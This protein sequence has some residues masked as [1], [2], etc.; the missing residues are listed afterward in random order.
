MRELLFDLRDSLRGFRRNRLY[1]ITVVATLAL[2]LGA[3]T[4]VFSI[5]NGV[6]LRPLA[7]PESQNLVSIREVIPRIAAQYPN[8]PANARHFEE[9]R[10]QA[11]SY[12][13]IAELDWRTITLTGV[14]EASQLVLLRA[15]GTVFDV[16]ETPVALGRTLTRE[17]ERR[18]RPNVVVISH[19]LW[20]E[21]LGGDPA[22]L[23]RT[24][25]M[26]GT[27]YTVVG[28]LPAGYQL[29]SF[30]TL[31]ESGSL[32]GQYDAVVPMRLDLNQ[33]GWMGQFN[34]P[35]IGRLKPDVGIEQA[36]SELNVLQQAVA[37]IARSETQEDVDLRGWIAP[38]EASIVGRAKLG[39]LLLLGAIAGVVLIACSNLANLSLTRTMGRLREAGVRSALGASQGRLARQAIVEQLVLAAAGGAL[40]LLV[41]FQALRLF[42][43]TAPIDLPR[44]G[45]VVIDAR[46][47]AFAA[48]VTVAT[49]LLVA[50]L[51]AWRVTRRDV[52]GLLR[53]SERG[54]TDRGGAGVRATLLSVQIAVSATLLVMTGLFVTSF[55]RLLRVDPGFSSDGVVSM[56]IKPIAR[57]YPDTP[58]RAALYDRILERVHA[59]PGVTAAA[60]TSMLPLN[61][62][63]WVDMVSRLDDARP[64][65]E[66][67]SANYR[68]VGPEYFQALAM[69]MLKGRSIEP[70]DRTAAVTP[71]VISAR[72]ADTLWPG[73]EAVGRQFRRADPDQHFEV[74]GVVADGHP[75]ALDADAPLMVYVPYWFNNEGKSVLVVRSRTDAGTLIG[76]L[77]RAVRDVDPEIA[78]A[79]AG[80]LSRVT[81]QVLA[82]RRYQMWLFIAFGAVAVVIATIGV[83]ATTAYGVSRR[84]REMNIR[85][86]LGARASQV[87][88][89]ILRQS[90]V[91]VLIGLLGAA[92]GALALGRFSE[93]LLFQVGAR[94][95][96]VIVSVLGAVGGIALIAAAVAMR[97]GLRIDPAAALRDE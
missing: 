40:G 49:G 93:S 80:P 3:T 58:E 5:V 38:L 61:G 46:V 74:V 48:A 32:T 56:E 59:M 83:Y 88:A 62:E 67:A 31:S 9:W 23:G 76:A 86:A 22:V 92:G 10:Q 37:R 7:Y 63:T 24:L 64:D 89:M 91:P 82:G 97:Q 27:P 52:Q 84:R 16:L 66:K 90:A 96:L 57:R 6:L 17:D 85:V 21:R 8:L 65:N 87:S 44:A 75:T 35:V 70:R 94:D 36:R 4:A 19:A 20:R 95:P 77:R 47:L 43:R 55:V 78:I 15:S 14:G 69:P 39:L 79:D 73:E 13:A 18:D 11:T 60:W 30:D 12:S 72:A 53:S 41:A 34:Y 25:M 51:P 28:V 33:V 71:A 2:T 42:V 1:A 26:G 68:F 81:R 54:A 50:L 45:E 29:P